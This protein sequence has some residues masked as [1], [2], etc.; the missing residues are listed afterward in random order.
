LQRP[1]G[2]WHAS[3]LDPGSFPGKETSGTGLYCYALAWGIN[4]RVLPASRYTTIVR[5]AWK[6][7]TEAVQ[8]D[9]RLGYVQQI[10]E[11]PETTNA[12]STEAYGTGAFLLAGSE[13]YALYKDRRIVR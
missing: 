13:V 8:P 7:L 3:L 9:G 11:K 2:T 5:R 4:H 10:G 1:D 12:S 6:A